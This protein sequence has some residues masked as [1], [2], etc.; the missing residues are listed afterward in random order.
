MTIAYDFAAIFGE[1]KARATYVGRN[2]FRRVERFVVLA[3]GIALGLSVGFTAAIGLGR[4]SLGPLIVSGVAFE[5]LALY[6]CAQTLRESLVRRAHGCAAASIAHAAALLA[7]PLAGLFAP[8]SAL[9]F[10]IAPATALSGL[11]LF[12]SCWGGPPRAV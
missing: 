1:R 7:W 6:L 11:V 3:G 12:A 2:E 5:A 8:V 9:A 10:W 4:P